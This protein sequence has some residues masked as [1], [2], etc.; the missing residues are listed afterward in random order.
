MLVICIEQESD[1]SI[2]IDGVIE[3]FKTLK[4]IGR[5]IELLKELFN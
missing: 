3:T 1:F 5:R 2:D 4:L